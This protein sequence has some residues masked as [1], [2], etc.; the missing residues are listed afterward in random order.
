[1]KKILI[2]YVKKHYIYL[3]IQTIFIFLNVYFVTYPAKIIGNLIDLLYDIPANQ[4][5]ILQ[6]ILYLFIVSIGLLLIRFPWRYLVTYNSRSLEKEL[7]NEL[8]KHFLKMKM[9]EIQNIKNGEIMS[10]FTKDVS[11]IRAAFYRLE[12]Y[13]TRII[14]TFLIGTFTMAQGVNLGLTA[15]TMLPIIITSYLIVKIKKYVETSFKI[16]QEYYTELSE[17]VQESTDAIRT[18]KAYSQEGNQLKEF[19][20]K[21]KKLKSANNAVDVH[22][23]LLTTCINVCFGLCYAISILYG[24]KLVLENTISIGDFVAF[25]GYIGIFI[26][27]VSWL[28]STISRFKRGQISYRRLENFLSLEKEKFLLVAPKEEINLKGDIKISHLSFH[29]PAYLEEVLE[30]INIVIPQGKTLGI[31]GTVG[32]GKTTLV[33]LLLRLYSVPDGMI[34]IGEKDINKIPIET[35]RKNI[36]Y[37]TQ[38]S[39]LFSNTIEKNISLFKKGYTEKEIMKSTKEAIIYDE[40]QEMSQ[41][42]YTMIGERGVDLSGGQ[43]QRIAISRAFLNNSDI[44]IF[45]DTFSALD[46]K[47]EEKLLENIKTMTQN[48]TCII[49]SNRISDLKDADEIVVLESGKMIEKGTHESLI[50]QRGNY[51]TF[52]SQQISKEN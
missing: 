28:P 39:F 43:K 52:Y 32:S 31:M 37:I 44:V 30:D 16:S 49:I 24:S 29:Y 12:S 33:N 45:D 34:Y 36:C 17:Y 51:Y 35:I 47:T 6:T 22:S 1:M 41:G 7:K 5:T 40:I 10:Y 14:A 19:I 26:G 20:R 48:K 38:D 42:I 4:A 50:A 46:N 27:P 23:T 21:N 9:N 2:R 3:I 13:G 15:I 25:N 18:T 8:F 11:E